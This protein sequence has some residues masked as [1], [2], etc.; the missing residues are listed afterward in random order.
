MKRRN[1]EGAGASKGEICLGREIKRV[2]GEG[3]PSLF[4]FRS[5]Q[6]LAP[7][8]LALEVPPFSRQR[9]ALTFFFPPHSHRCQKPTTLPRAIAKAEFRRE[10]TKTDFGTLPGAKRVSCRTA[11]H[12]SS[13]SSARVT[14]STTRSH[15]RWRRKLS[16]YRVS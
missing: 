16:D 13:A 6:S 12:A 1:R 14:H 3:E 10:P 4:A 15:R 9:T 8:R 2:R 11:I 7:A 5:F